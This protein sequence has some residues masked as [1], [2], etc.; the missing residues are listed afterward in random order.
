MEIN[1]GVVQPE[2]LMPFYGFALVMFFAYCYPIARW[3]ISLERRY[4]VKL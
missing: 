3:T 2:L 4:A 1:P